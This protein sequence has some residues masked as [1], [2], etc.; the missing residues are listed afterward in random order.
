MRQIV[1]SLIAMV[2]FTI[3]LGF[4]YTLAVTGIAG[5]AWPDQAGGSLVERDGEAVGSKLLAQ[6]FFGDGNFW[7]RPSFSGYNA[8]TGLD[9]TARALSYPSNLGPLNPDLRAAIA[10]RVAI[11]G[12]G[13]PVDLV[14]GSGSSLDPHISVAAARWQ[15]ARVA[16]ARNVP[17]EKLHVLIDSQTESW[18]GRRY[19]NVLL[20]NLAL[21]EMA[22]TSQ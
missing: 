4:G 17:E 16:E 20:L 6:P 9:P 3:L 22:G 18:L 8:D 10:E 13:V 7:P 1:R 19:V 5:L 14:T 15:V 12:E 21:D 2:V 11:Y